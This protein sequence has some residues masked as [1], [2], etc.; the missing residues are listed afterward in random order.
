MRGAGK[1]RILGGRRDAAQEDTLI[2][3]GFEEIQRQ[4]VERVFGRMAR[5]RLWLIPLFLALFAWLVAVDRTPWRVTALAIALPSFAAFILLELR[6]YRL[7]G[8]RPGAIDFNL[9]FATG[10]VLL[11]TTASGGID[12][13]FIPIVVLVGIATA[14]FASP[15]VSAWLFAVQ[16]AWVWALAAEA[17]LDLLPGMA[18]AAVGATRGAPGG[19]A[20]PLALVISV[21]LSVVRVAGRTV[22]ASLDAML[23]RTVSAQQ[24]ALRSHAE[25]AEELTALSGEIAHELKNPLSSVK[26]L[27]ALLA[28]HL[29]EG[30]G[31]ERLG[32][33]RREVDRMQ[34]TLDEFLNFSRPLVPL[35]LGTSDVAALCREIVSL[36]EGMAQERGVLLQAPA[37]PVR[38][39]CDPRKVRQILI[40]LVQNAIDASPRG[41]AIELA[42]EAGGEGAVALRV[43]DRGR[44]I[45]PSLGDAAFKPGVTTKESGSGLGLTIARA[46][47]R[48]HGGDL[49]LRRRDGGGTIAEVTL[50]DE[51]HLSPA[52]AGERSYEGLG[53]GAAS[54]PAEGKAS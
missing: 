7:H 20:L 3:P 43:L 8:L 27:A 48:Q 52:P 11:L 49:T 34:S 53:E 21:I 42:A 33:L 10:G 46:L 17:I 1:R 54:R 35:A 2:P 36:H 15:R 9:G 32:V 39:R 40:N 13:P 47:A 45:E 28:Q 19:R 23:A 25:R 50:P 37:E 24:D 12:S 29:P 14:L 26:G 18:L 4:E 41:G 6:R 38:A 22:R 51:M 31:A 44:G 5:A 16:L 30:K